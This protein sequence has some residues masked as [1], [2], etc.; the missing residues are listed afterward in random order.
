MLSVRLCPKRPENPRACIKPPTGATFLPTRQDLPN[1]ISDRKIKLI[2]F[3]ITQPISKIA[4]GH[5]SI[6][7]VTGARHRTR[8]A[9]KGY[10]TVGCIDSPTTRMCAPPATYS[11]LIQAAAAGNSETSRPPTSASNGG[12]GRA[13]H[14]WWVTSIPPCQRSHSRVVA[15]PGNPGSAR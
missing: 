1:Q 2:G 4:R 13:R 9:Y 6:S 8:P 14:S 7:M 5:V 10:I 3:S 12:N 11:G 15:S